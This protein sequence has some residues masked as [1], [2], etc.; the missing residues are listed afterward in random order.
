[1]NSIPAFMDK[2]RWIGQLAMALQLVQ[3]STVQAQD[4]PDFQ[5]RL[6]NLESLWEKAPDP[7]KRRKASSLADSTMFMRL[8]GQHGNAAK[9]LDIA[10]ATLDS[11][12]DGRNSPNWH[13][14]L[15]LKVADRFVDPS[16][17]TI[18]CSILMAYMPEPPPPPGS[19]ATVT[20]EVNQRPM[21][22]VLVTLK[23]KR[24]NFELKPPAG[25][26]TITISLATEA[27]DSGAKLVR[28]TSAT[29]QSVPNW[30]STKARMTAMR[31]EVMKI[32]DGLGKLTWIHRMDTALS[33]PDA[34]PGGWQQALSLP[35]IDISD[36]EKNHWP[37]PVM[38]TDQVLVFPGGKGGRIIRVRLP[39]KSAEAENNP[40][41]LVALHGLGDTEDSWIEGYGGKLAKHCDD[42]KWI[43]VSP[44][45]GW[46]ADLKPMLEKWCGQAWG[47]TGLV[48]FSKGGSQAMACVAERPA[49]WTAIVTIGA[50]GRTGSGEAYRNLPMFLGIGIDDP[51][52]A[53]CV[54]MVKRMLDDGQRRLHFHQADN[55]GHLMGP[56]AILPRA[57]DF[58][59]GFLGGKQ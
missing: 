44:R 56:V 33:G 20:W 8:T 1:M 34:W 45:N 52:H 23:G 7:S 58:L 22:D 42:R 43:L 28:K 10:I 11:R 4:D 30:T 18:R 17:D 32:P 19:T 41:A 12:I 50:S 37:S 14:A 5:R 29:V 35:D 2:V 51:A 3:A 25:L 59:D 54:S 53:S 21:P 46:D 6:S 26:S 49:D 15:D 38:G 39:A 47:R 36:I 9:A 55:T 40:C 57:L 24:T 27:T 16:I 13:D 48:G 31:K